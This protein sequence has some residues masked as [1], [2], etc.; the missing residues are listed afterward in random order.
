[1]DADHSSTRGLSKTEAV[2]FLDAAAKDG[3]RS[4]ALA[5][6]LVHTGVRISEA[7]AATHDD[8]QHDTGHRVLVVSRKGGKRAKIALPAPVLDAL[9]AYLGASTA[10]GA[11]VIT[12]ASA[13]TDAPIFTTSTGKRWAASEAFRTVQRLARAA[14][15]E[16]QVSPH[17]LR[18]THAT[19]ALD[20]GVPLRDLQDSMGHADP[21]TT[22]RY[23][24]AR[25]RLER[26]SAYAVASVLS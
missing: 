24:R 19:L 10:Q 22:R 2:A 1:M 26:S 25:A 8:L 4:R 14:G 18:H 6:L 23:D 20:A 3:P 7:L 9:A 16:G 21:R 11:E 13:Q 5:A 17:G 15:I 12:N